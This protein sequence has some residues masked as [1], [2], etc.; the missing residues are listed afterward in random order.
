MMCFGSVPS[1]TELFLKTL[2][3]P[4]QQQLSVQAQ[5]SIR[6]ATI[7]WARVLVCLQHCSEM[8]L[9]VL[10]SYKWNVICESEDPLSARVAY[11]YKHLGFFIG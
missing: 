7:P 11:L 1:S 4:I 8:E 6:K 3:Y 5:M 9:I 2:H 10:F